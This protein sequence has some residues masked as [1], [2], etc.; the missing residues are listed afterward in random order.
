MDVATPGP[1]GRIAVRTAGSCW[2]IE[3]EAVRIGSDLL[4]AVWGGERPHIGAVAAASARASLAD[5]AK[6]SATSSV[7]TYPGHKEDVVVKLVAEALSAALRTNVVVTAGM[8][9]DGLSADA[10]ASVVERCRE[11]VDLLLEALGA[12]SV[13]RQAEKLSPTVLTSVNLARYS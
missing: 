3:A 4:V 13:G 10:I 6:W 2:V 1:L 9:W 7:L 5:S 12:S 11:I 8:H